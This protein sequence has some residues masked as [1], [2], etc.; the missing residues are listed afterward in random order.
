MATDL[1]QRCYSGLETRQDTLRFNPV[2]PMALGSLGFDIRYRGHL[3]HLEFTTEVARLHVDLAEGAPMTV[4]IK[5]V[6][7]T[8]GPGETMEVEIA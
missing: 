3:V 8:V 5:G 6:T 2:I 4:D 1:V 7:A